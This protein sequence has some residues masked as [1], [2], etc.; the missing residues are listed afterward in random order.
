[1]VL[2]TY[3]TILKEIVKSKE[4][5]VGDGQDHTLT[6]WLHHLA[7][8]N[9][10]VN[11]NLMLPLKEDGLGESLNLIIPLPKVATSNTSRFSYHL[12]A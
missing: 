1:M 12:S 3:Q 11:L 10:S 7:V 9:F 8:Y 2:T 5:W 4:Q 6:P